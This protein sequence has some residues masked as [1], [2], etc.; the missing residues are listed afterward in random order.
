MTTR[1]AAPFWPWNLALM[2]SVAFWKSVPG[3]LNSF[4]SEPW[5]A[6]FSPMRATKIPSH[7][8]TTRHGWQAQWP[9]TRARAPVWAIRRSSS[10]R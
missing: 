4:T 9:A 3:T 10:S 2:R 1:S 8:K 6:A 7:V 5:N